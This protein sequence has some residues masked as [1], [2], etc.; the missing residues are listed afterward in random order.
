MAYTNPRA[1]KM[2]PQPTAVQCDKAYHRMWGL[3]WRPQ[4]KFEIHSGPT[5]HPRSAFRHLPTLP[6]KV[7][8]LRGQLACLDY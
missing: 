7:R 4:P 6:S 2:P 3:V 8:N 5:P 1:Y